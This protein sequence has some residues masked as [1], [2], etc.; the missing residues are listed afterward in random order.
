[1]SPELVQHEWMVGRIWKDLNGSESCLCYSLT[2]L[3]A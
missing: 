2:N 3:F 1:M